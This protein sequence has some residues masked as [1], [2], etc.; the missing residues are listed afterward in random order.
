MSLFME[1]YGFRLTVII[2]NLA[3]CIHMALITSSV[4]YTAWYVVWMFTIYYVQGG[5]NGIVPGSSAYFFGTVTGA[6]I[7]G[8]FLYDDS[9]FSV[10]KPISENRQPHK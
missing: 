1:K 10:A 2:L 4:N 9:I 7:V 6:A 5:I 8:F 3:A